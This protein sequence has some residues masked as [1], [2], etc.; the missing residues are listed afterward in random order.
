M[1]K[2]FTKF[3]II[4]FLCRNDKHMKILRIYKIWRAKKYNLAEQIS[5]RI[6]YDFWMKRKGMYNL[7]DEE[8][9]NCINNLCNMIAG[10]T[11]YK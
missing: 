9:T 7:T 5:A 6:N 4:S 8:Y 10:K 11:K 3:D 1:S 2:I